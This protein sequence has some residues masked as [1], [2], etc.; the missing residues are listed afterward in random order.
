[1]ISI[2][3]TIILNK[4]YLSNVIIFLPG[5]IP[6]V[7]ARTYDSQVEKNNAFGY[8]WTMNYEKEIFTTH[9][10]VKEEGSDPPRYTMKSK[11]IIQNGSGRGVAFSCEG[12]FLMQPNFDFNSIGGTY[13]P[14]NFPTEYE[15]VKVE[16]FEGV[17]G[18]FVVYYKNGMCEVFRKYQGSVS[19]LDNSAE[20]VHKILLWK[21][22]D[23][24]GNS[25]EINYDTELKISS[26]VNSDGNSASF[27]YNG[28]KHITKVQDNYGRFTEYKYNDSGDLTEFTNIDGITT[29]YDYWFWTVS[30]SVANTFSSHN[31]KSITFPNSSSVT[32]EYENANT[33][34]SSFMV[35][36]P[37]CVRRIAFPSGKSSVFTYN[38][39]NPGQTKV[40]SVLEAGVF[41]YVDYNLNYTYTY[42]SD[43]GIT[44][45]VSYELVYVFNPFRTRSLTGDEELPDIGG[46]GEVTRITLDSEN[47][48]NKVYDRRPE[49]PELATT[50]DYDTR[51]NPISI[52]SKTGNLSSFDYDDAG[53]LIKQTDARG[54][55][56]EY[57]YNDETWNLVK[58]IDAN[59]NE[60]VFDYNEKGDMIRK[61]DSDG[62]EYFYS[63]D[64]FGNLVSISR[65]GSLEGNTVTLTVNY[66]YDNYGNRLTAID[67][68]GNLTE[69]VYDGFNRLVEVRNH[70]QGQVYH[71]YYAYDEMGNR[72]LRIENCRF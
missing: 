40:S 11:L 44:T 35:D 30:D 28:S 23:R 25:L 57:V 64:G 46:T 65:T 32:I 24:N 61:Q 5:H 53:R 3:L 69:Y 10:I 72:V 18:C 43:Y 13:L 51:H 55:E 19:Y 54:N 59:G 34:V 31:L 42:T 56:T 22:L 52:T 1:M 29:E 26:V 58:V 15:K 68:K 45:D 14:P 9:Q 49:F 4:S 33:S 48:V 50:I 67:A 60:T 71:T 2:I 47:N 37:D 17:P 20:P 38:Y 63:Y 16:E 62:F 6:I 21:V 12:G 8:G 70:N 27:F 36:K 39:P 7:V 66:T 41:S